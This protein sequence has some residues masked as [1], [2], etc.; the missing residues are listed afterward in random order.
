M[1]LRFHD[2]RR[3]F[4]HQDDRRLLKLLAQRTSIPL[5]GG[6]ADRTADAIIQWVANGG[7]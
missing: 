3:H 2:D 4:L 6:G 1:S 5:S 7:P